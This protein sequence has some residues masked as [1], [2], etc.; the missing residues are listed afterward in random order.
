[1]KVKFILP[2]LL[3]LC[4]AGNAFSSGYSKFI[5]IEKLA[6]KGSVRIKLNSKG[7]YQGYCMEMNIVNNSADTCFAWVEAGRRLISKD[8]KQQDIFIVKNSYVTIPPKGKKR[9][10]LFGFCCI[11]HNSSPAKGSA[12]SVGKMEGEDWQ[13]LANII[14]AGHFDNSAIQAA[15]WSISNDHPISS[16]NRGMDNKN[17]QL[18]RTVADLKHE[19][20]PW[21]NV[22]YKSE[23]NRVFSNK[24]DHIY[25][26]INYN[27][28][29][30]GDISYVIRNKYGVVQVMLLEDVPKNK[31]LNSF[32]L[33]LDVTGWKDGTYYFEVIQDGNKL[34]ERREFEINTNLN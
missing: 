32:F 29:Y 22:N 26:D 14:D 13:H 30:Y 19:E 24:P 4:S 11:S 7:G 5:S 31:G 8:E 12:F 16:I 17:M 18:L 2:V 23:S 1:M 15:V 9:S 21:Y 6:S 3:I 34:I 27:L 25:A 28:S 10:D 20:L 33:D